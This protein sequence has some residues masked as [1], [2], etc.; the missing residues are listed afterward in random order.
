MTTNFKVD[1][2]DLD[3]RFAGKGLPEGAPGFIGIPGTVG[4]GVGICPAD[5][6][7]LGYTPLDGCF[8]P[9]HENYGNY[10]D[11]FGSQM[12]YIPRFYYRQSG[13]D[14]ED[15]TIDISP[16]PLEGY[17]LD[18]AFISSNH[19]PIN[20][21][22][23]EVGEY[24]P[25]RRVS[26]NVATG[27]SKGVHYSR[28][29]TTGS[30]S[31]EADPTNTFSRTDGG[32]FVVEGFTVGMSIRTIGMGVGNDQDGFSNVLF[33]TITAVT[34]SIITVSGTAVV[35]HNVAGG[36]EIR[37]K[38]SMTV[39][40]PGSTIYPSMTR[41]IGSFIDEEMETG[42]IV[43]MYKW[44]NS[45]NN[46]LFTVV[47]VEDKIVWFEL[48]DT[49]MVSETKNVSQ[50]YDDVRIQSDFR[51]DPDM[52][53]YVVKD[54]IFVDKF[55]VS[56]SDC[57]SEAGKEPLTNGVAA[58][59][60][61]TGWN[62]YA[63]GTKIPGI[64]LQGTILAA[65]NVLEEPEVHAM[66]V[67]VWG[68][69]MRLAICQAQNSGYQGGAGENVYDRAVCAWNSSNPESLLAGPG[70]NNYNG[71]DASRSWTGLTGSFYLSFA[72]S[73]DITGASLTGSCVQGLDF[74]SH[75]GQKCGVCDMVGNLW[76]WMAGISTTRNFI[77]DGIFIET[78]Y[79]STRRR[80]SDY[81]PS[82]YNAPYANETS[83]PGWAN[84]TVVNGTWIATI[85]PGDVAVYRYATEYPP[86]SDEMIDINESTKSVHVDFDRNAAM[87]PVIGL[88]SEDLLGEDAMWIARV[89]STQFIADAGSIVRGG[90]YYQGTY[91]GGIV[92]AGLWSIAVAT[93]A[94]LDVDNQPWLLSPAD[95]IEHFCARGVRLVPGHGV[96]EYEVRPP[97]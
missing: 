16:V 20:F 93:L 59:E 26:T 10:L 31:A 25:I 33:R 46:G 3:D 63:D 45:A 51:P 56:G 95:G 36:E 70:G 83:V 2:V 7:P 18:R 11:S 4:F 54:G 44:T 8:V 27:R 75:N 69:L 74:V 67:W 30:F 37:A 48:K 94:N 77:N 29:E 43:Y 68:M 32:S 38:I 97:D 15:Q 28:F 60:T 50:T 41:N 92:G 62:D 12:V 78:I 90:C 22:A 6:L 14:P 85:D 87:I 86:F 82:D 19:T 72:A 1:G 42:T 21:P 17:V 5:I 58:S 91:T 66:P 57:I 96:F 55:P 34:D 89:N 53:G 40:P 47:E 13:N 81:V 73:S 64:E 84:V 80:F 88:A 76:E 49:A 23:P 52:P 39:A 35:L 24:Y 61:R 65:R 9:S 71:Y 79:N